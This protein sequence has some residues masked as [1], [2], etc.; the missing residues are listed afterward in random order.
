MPRSKPGVLKFG[1]AS[2]LPGKLVKIASVGDYPEIFCVRIL[3]G[4]I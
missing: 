2:E 4:D 1:W 3:K